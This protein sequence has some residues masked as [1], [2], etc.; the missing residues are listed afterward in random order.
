MCLFQQFLPELKMRRKKKAEVFIAPLRSALAFKWTTDNML[1]TGGGWG[2][3][4]QTT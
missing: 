4:N 1:M 3:P 2:Q